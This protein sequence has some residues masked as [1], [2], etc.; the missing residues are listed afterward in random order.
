MRAF[1]LVPGDAGS[2]GGTLSQLRGG[3]RMLAQEPSIT[4][5]FVAESRRGEAKTS[6]PGQD[7]G[8]PRGLLVHI[9]TSH[10]S[11]ERALKA[12]S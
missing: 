3:G 2:E 8:L 12:P 10:P 5:A 9:P 1:P 4:Y 7:G 11:G 6:C